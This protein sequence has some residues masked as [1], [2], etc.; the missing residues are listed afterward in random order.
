MYYSITRKK[1]FGEL[2][3]V[4]LTS[5]NKVWTIALDGR[6]QPLLLLILFSSS[7]FSSLLVDFVINK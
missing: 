4:L 3:V 6:T 2:V 5:L 1:L 7:L